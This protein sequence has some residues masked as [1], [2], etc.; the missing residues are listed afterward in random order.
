MLISIG[1]FFFATLKNRL[2]YIVSLKEKK[3]VQQKET[4][5]H[6]YR[7]ITEATFQCSDLSKSGNSGN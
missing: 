2:N 5:T 6:L 7:E 1:F 4:E 3:K